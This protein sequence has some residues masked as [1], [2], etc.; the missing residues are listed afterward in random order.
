MIFL[1]LP[2]K[3]E[4]V[5]FAIELVVK[6]SGSVFVVIVN[7]LLAAQSIQL[8][9]LDEWYISPNNAYIS[10]VSLQLASFGICNGV[11]AFDTSRVDERGRQ[12]SAEL[13]IRTD[14]YSYQC[15]DSDRFSITSISLEHWHS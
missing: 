11:A 8:Q 6:V 10:R 2:R 1:R 13:G 3:K 15:G 9:R 7:L 12:S 14:S 5:Y 4:Q